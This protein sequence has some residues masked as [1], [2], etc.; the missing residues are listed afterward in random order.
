MD[1]RS[2]LGLVLIAAIMI[3]FS[4]F[5]KPDEEE[6]D[7]DKDGKKKQKKEIQVSEE[8]AE[9][10]LDVE[11]PIADNVT[12]IDSIY[13]EKAQSLVLNDSALIANID[14]T[15]ID[16]VISSEYTK[17]I[18]AKE[19]KEETNQLAKDYGDFYVNLEGSDD[20]YVLENEKI[21]IEF[22]SKGAQIRKAEL[23]GF[24]SYFNYHEGNAVDENPYI[25]IDSTNRFA[26]NIV[27][28]N[29]DNAIDFWTDDLYFT[30]VGD[31]SENELV[32]RAE[33]QKGGY[34]EIAY[35]LDD[36]YE[37]SQKIRSYNL[38]PSTDFETLEWEMK[39]LQ[40]EKSRW[41][42]NQVAGVFY[43][44]SEETRDYLTEGTDDDD[45]IEASLDWLAFKQSF[46][47][48]VLIPNGN[49]ERGGEIAHYVIE[50][51]SSPYIKKYSAEIE[52]PGV[53]ANTETEY[54]WYLG[55]NDLAYLETYDIGMHKLVNHGWKIFGWINRNFFLPLYQSLD[56]MGLGQGLIIFLMTIIV[57]LITMPLVFRNYR[58]SAKM[59]L[60][61]PEIEELAKKYPDPKDA[62]K[63]QQETMA[64]Y[65]S[66]GVNPMAGCL[67][68]L[69]QMPILFAMFRLVPTLVEL[70]QESFL[71][72]DDLS[73][74]DAIFSWNQ[75]IPIL[76]DF[77]GNH[78][79]L[80]TLLMAG[81]TLAY[82]RVN[83]TQMTPTQPGMPNM[84]FIMYLFPIMMIFFF[85]RYSAGLSYYYFLSSVL[86]MAV[87][88]I[89][90]K[91]FIDEDKLLKQLQENKKKPKKKS[92]FQQRLEDMQ[93]QQ[94]QRNKK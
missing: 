84:K 21:R 23:K 43:K 55:P 13:Y 28:F 51:E 7:S 67:P 2:I 81:A 11:E 58:S 79:S 44:Y 54:T 64:L 15:Q 24:T 40:N 48:A 66:T 4:L 22:A 19:E 93:R 52:S 36:K 20:I 80:F 45:E 57:R 90:K 68:M 94:A 27:D 33:N 65:R 89:I 6:A 71:W 25:L 5:N 72:A 37:L 50:D 1:K 16:S 59:K 39:A 75:H 42:E 82:T 78:V 74:F 53:S 41:Q 10:T 86:S 70:R 63:K 61:K 31:V 47:S 46:F 85:N 30:P 49:F 17:L 91:Y 38:S 35:V 60:L 12:E 56:G 88:F 77:Y 73:S 29:G 9:D 62:M 8:T 32:L 83:M 34:I 87:M 26:F 18:G 3:G 69:I 92:R 76:S 14:S